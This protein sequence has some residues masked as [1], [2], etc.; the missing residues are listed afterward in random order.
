MLPFYEVVLSAVLAKGTG[1]WYY[2]N[3]IDNDEAMKEAIYRQDR[4]GLGEAGSMQE[5]QHIAEH[6]EEIETQRNERHDEIE[7]YVKVYS[8]KKQKERGK[9]QKS[10]EVQE[11][12]RQRSGNFI[13]NF[14][15]YLYL[16][17]E[18]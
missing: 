6:S 17:I 12:K 13:L 10:F 18:N 4:I 14:L 16:Q 3:I 8:E 15:I 5:L 1:K 11:T 2:Y 9:K 7:T